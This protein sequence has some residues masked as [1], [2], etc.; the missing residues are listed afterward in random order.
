[1]RTS[2]RRM[3]NAIEPHG[4]M[5]DGSG[6]VI[7]GIG[8][9]GGEWLLVVDGKVMGGGSSAADV[10]VMLDQLATIRQADGD[11]VMN[12]Y[13]TTFKTCAERDA[14]EDGMSLYEYIERARDEMAS[15]EAGD[16]HGAIISS[17][18]GVTAG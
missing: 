3:I 7:A 18:G 17:D 10:M 8:R 9:Q 11:A 15:D 6:R 1:M 13:S 14:Q 16:V 12:S 4:E 5:R 2:S